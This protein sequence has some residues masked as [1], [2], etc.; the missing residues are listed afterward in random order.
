MAFCRSGRIPPPTTIIMNAPEARAV[1]EPSPSTARLKIVPHMTE[2]QSPQRTRRRAESGTW[3]I[4]KPEPVNT[5][6]EVLTP[7]GTNIATSMRAAATAAAQLN[8]VRLEITPLMK[9][10]TKRPM[11]MRNQ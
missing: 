9:L 5:G 1:A 6:I 4:P 3:T 11:S 7:A 8:W 2:V 10:D